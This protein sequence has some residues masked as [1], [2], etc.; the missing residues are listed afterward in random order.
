M[1]SKPP[2]PPPNGHSHVVHATSPP[3]PPVSYSGC[4][5]TIRSVL[6]ATQAF[7]PVLRLLQ[8]ETKVEFGPEGDTIAG[9]IR[10]ICINGPH[11]A[12]SYEVVYWAGS[13]RKTVWLD[14]NEVREVNG[15][16]VSIGFKP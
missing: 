8:P 4:D 13:D 5:A 7:N 2:T 15:A 1:S 11:R 9:A 6:A 10:Q 3:P 12:V 16:R 14:A